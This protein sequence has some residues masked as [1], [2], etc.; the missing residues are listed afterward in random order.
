VFSHVVDE[1]AHIACGMQYLSKGVYRYE[2]QHPPLARVAAAIGPYLADV[3][4][5]NGPEMWAE[6]LTLLYEGG[7]Y[8]RN[9]FL[10]R[11]GILPFFWIAS[12]VVC[13]WAKRYC[14]E[15]CASFSVLLFSTSRAVPLRAPRRSGPARR[16]TSLRDPNS[17]EPEAL[18]A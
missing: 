17:F 10:A 6:V 8:D 9:L 4:S 14:G 18:I 5:L 1:P 7:H 11:L 12:L 13:V 3:R 16:T 2:H 15:P